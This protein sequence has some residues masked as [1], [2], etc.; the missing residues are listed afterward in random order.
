M[1]DLCFK[2]SNYF[3][4]PK[5]AGGSHDVSA[6]DVKYG[7]MRETLY[8]WGIRLITGG[9]TAVPSFSGRGIRFRK[10]RLRSTREKL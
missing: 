9:Q 6:A 1:D 10:R 5:T 4:P 3:T 8:R 2:I 7:P